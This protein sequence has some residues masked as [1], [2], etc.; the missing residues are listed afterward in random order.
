MSADAVG[1]SR[2][3]SK[4]LGLFNFKPSDGFYL[5]WINEDG[6]VSSH[7]GYTTEPFREGGMKDY[8][9]LEVCFDCGQAQGVWPQAFPDDTRE[10]VL[11]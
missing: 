9:G 4:R 1:C 2:C 6:S 10:E 7:D 8:F 3:G 5:G 11:G